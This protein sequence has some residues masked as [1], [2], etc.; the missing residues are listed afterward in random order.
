MLESSE[1]L[2]WHLN[3]NDRAS[4]SRG[5]AKGSNIT[6]HTPQLASSNLKARK[7]KHRV[8]GIP[9]SCMPQVDQGML[10]EHQELE[11]EA[12]K[13]IGKMFKNVNFQA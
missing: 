9:E 1:Y 6:R 4:P 12:R 13:V 10:A 11:G 7:G 3:V 2:S 5:G 8:L